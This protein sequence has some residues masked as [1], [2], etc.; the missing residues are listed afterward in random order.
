MAIEGQVR[1]KCDVKVLGRSYRYQGLTK[2]RYGDVVW[3]L[4][5]K[6]SHPKQDKL[7]FFRI[8]QKVVSA[9]PL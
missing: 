6:M 2:E 7:G 9:T 4:G 5:N 3:Q 8:G 1:V